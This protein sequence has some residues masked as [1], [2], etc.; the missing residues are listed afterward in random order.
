LRMSDGNR[1][2]SCQM[3]PCGWPQVRDGFAKNILAGHGNSVPFLLGSTIFHWL[4]FI[5]PWVWW[6]FGGGRFALGLGLTGL[7]LRALTAAFTRQRILD[8]L[9]MPLSVVLVTRIAIK[10]IAWRITGTAIWKG[11]QLQLKN[12]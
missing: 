6:I 3:Y 8:S 11:R 1:L 7:L 10:S 12:R 9:L 4:V 5:I 2:V